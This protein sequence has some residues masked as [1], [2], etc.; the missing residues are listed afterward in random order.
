MLSV[1]IRDLKVALRSLARAPGFALITVLML[2]I[3]IGANTA[4]F[5]AVNGVLLDPL[6]YPEPSQLVSVTHTAPG[7]DFDQ[8]PLSP[9]TYVLVK[10]ENRVFTEIGAY[11]GGGTA[12]LTGDHDPL[13][14]DAAEVSW[15]M[16]AVLGLTFPMGRGFSQ[17]EDLPD[18]PEAVVLSH[19][20]WQETYG[21]DPNILGRAVQIDGRSRTIVGVLPQRIDVPGLDVDVWLPIQI[22]PDAP[23]VGT[24]G[25]A[26]IA[27]MQPGRTVETASANL[28]PLIQRLEENLEGAGELPGLHPKRAVGDAGRCA[29]GVHRG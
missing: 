19:G 11:R 21:A 17:E 7:F 24:F 20:V 2:A 27:R 18:G 25:T 26:S 23:D 1:F 8:I 6:D 28:Q 13:V 15:E 9:D 22:D 12:N 3:G 16:P 10:K 5:S 29:Q 4:I 14:L